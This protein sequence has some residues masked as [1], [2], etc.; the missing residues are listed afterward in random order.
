MALVHA[1]GWRK[2]ASFAAAL[3]ASAA[4]FATPGALPQ[5]FQRGVVYSSWDG[6]YPASGVHGD[7]LAHFESLG[8]EWLQLMTFAHQP[9]VNR[10]EIRFGR[11]PWPSAF[12]KAARAKGMKILLK[13]H[14]FSR[15]FYDGSQR[16]RGS[17]AMKSPADRAAWFANYER[18]IVDQ[19]RQAAADGVEM[20][21]VGLEYVEMTRDAAPEW[22][23]I[24]KAVRAVFPGKLTY[25]ADYNHETGHIDW[26]DALDV[27][28]VNGY[29]QLAEGE[30]PAASALALGIAPHLA[31]CTALAERFKRPIVFTEIGFP[32]VSR[33][34]MRPWQ[35]PSGD[36][37]PDPALQARLFETVFQACSHAKWCQGMYWW[38]YYELPEKTPE[39]VDYTPRGKPA[40]AVLKRWYG[41]EQGLRRSP[42][43]PEHEARST[44]PSA[45]AS[46]QAEVK[47][48]K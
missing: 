31:R 28:G 36:E 5:S 43:A 34:A 16:W 12:I 26:W 1:L 44:K 8:V 48:E 9:D 29:F 42:A 7:H 37:T 3:L 21:S 13:P 33:A 32:S 40:E 6:S 23:R 24:I 45:A 22:R 27:I 10:P 2:P 4:A 15:Q 25:A 38:K 41:G 39:A 30:S 47:A 18:F 35:W 20:L 11:S 14:V 17:I 46:K 19:A